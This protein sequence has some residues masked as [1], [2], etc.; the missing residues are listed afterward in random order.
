MDRLT[1]E[2]MFDHNSVI[3]V[4]EYRILFLDY[5]TYRTQEIKFSALENKPQMCVDC[6]GKGSSVVF[7][8]IL[9][10]SL[11]PSPP[12]SPPPF[13]LHLLTLYRHG[14]SFATVGL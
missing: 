5:V 12:P 4:A 9:R 6:I 3:I 1:C 13:V 14:W 11:P 8:G 10:P 2:G 7:G